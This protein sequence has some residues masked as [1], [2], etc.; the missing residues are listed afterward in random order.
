MGRDA[1]VDEA[2]ARV[3]EKQRAEELQQVVDFQIKQLGQAD[4]M[5]MAARLRRTLLEEAPE[6]R[7]EEL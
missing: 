3:A 5:T 2:N 1:L 4:P 6:E 7:R